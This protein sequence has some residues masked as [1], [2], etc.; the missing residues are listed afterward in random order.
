MVLVVIFV[1]LVVVVVAVVVVVN[2]V[3]CIVNFVFWLL[4][5]ANETFLYSLVKLDY[6]SSRQT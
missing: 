5:L 2:V 1:V 6:N 3:V 4:L